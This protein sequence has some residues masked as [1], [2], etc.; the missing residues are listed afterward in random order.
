MVEESCSKGTYVEVVKKRRTRVRNTD[1]DYVNGPAM[2]NAIKA[3]YESG[4]REPPLEVVRAVEQ[5]CERLATKYNFRN[6]S[7]IDEM[8]AEG[9]LA[10]TI[11]VMEKKYDPYE[12]TNPF[13]YFTRIAYNAFVSVIKVEHKE[14]YIKHKELENYMIDANIRGENIEDYKMDDSGRIEKLINQFEGKKN[15][16]EED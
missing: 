9:K 5:I 16:S 8:I 2:H 15:E 7:Y 4:D 14:T 3:W 1:R 10:C 12:Y 13:A 11:A 6:Y